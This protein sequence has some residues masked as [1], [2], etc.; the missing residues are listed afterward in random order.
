MPTTPLYP[1]TFFIRP[2]KRQPR[3][4]NRRTVTMPD[5][6]GPHVRLVFSEMARLHVT[7]DEVEDGSGVRRASVKAWRRKNRPG[8]ESLEAVLGFLGW[9]FV[10]VPALE[11]LPPEMAGELTALALKLH[12]NIPTTWSALIDIGVEQKLLR[13]TADERRAVIEARKANPTP[14][15]RRRKPANDNREQSAETAA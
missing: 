13:M 3:R 15:R 7:Y 9:G 2:P 10:P 1:E 4:K 12:T 5:G 8:L 14:R 11:V 6:V